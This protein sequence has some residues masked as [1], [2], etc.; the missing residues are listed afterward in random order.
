MVEILSKNIFLHMGRI[1][2]F[3]WAQ[4]AYKGK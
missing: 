3:V 2:L 4:S 1:L